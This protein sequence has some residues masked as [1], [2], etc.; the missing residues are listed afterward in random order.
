MDNPSTGDAILQ[1]VKVEVTIALGKARPTMA[2]LGR[3]AVDTVL[4]LDC[5]IDDPVDLYVGNRLV[6]EGILEEANDAEPGSIA[7]RVSKIFDQSS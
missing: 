5:V 6:A 3:M 1:S 4:P 7:V 2:E